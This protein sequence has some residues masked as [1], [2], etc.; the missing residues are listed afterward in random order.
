MS[1]LMIVHLIAETLSKIGGRNPYRIFE[2]IDKMLAVAETGL[3][4]D[5]FNG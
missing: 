1:R 5:L 4:A 2:L 3:S